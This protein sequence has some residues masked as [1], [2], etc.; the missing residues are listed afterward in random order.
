MQNT[1]HHPEKVQLLCV[2]QADLL[3]GHTHPVEVAL[4]VK[5]R[6]SESARLLMLQDSVPGSKPEGKTVRK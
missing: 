2:V 1:G 6:V 5:Q 3:H 4:V